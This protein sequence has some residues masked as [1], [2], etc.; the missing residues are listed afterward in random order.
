MSDVMKGK[1]RYLFL[2]SCRFG[3]T[4]EL[5][6]PIEECQVFYVGYEGPNLTNLI[7]NYN[8]CQV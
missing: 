7:L 5:R 2:T 3:R 4:F 8:K 1:H 6:K